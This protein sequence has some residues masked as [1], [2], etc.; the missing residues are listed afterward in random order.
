M[1]ADAE[2]ALVETGG[3]GV[4]NIALPASLLPR[5]GYG[6]TCGTSDASHEISRTTMERK[7]G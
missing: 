7:E 2:S 5:Y 6:W 1:T 3:G 4:R